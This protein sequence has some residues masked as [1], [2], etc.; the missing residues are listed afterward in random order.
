MGEVLCSI[1]TYI[2]HCD[3]SGLMVLGLFCF[4]IGGL[5]L[6]TSALRYY[7]DCSVVLTR[8]LAR[9]VSQIHSTLVAFCALSSTWL[10]PFRIRAVMP[11][12]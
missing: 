1:G 8:T 4:Y 3:V 12:T 10:K 11:Q 2:F 9:Y 6:P 5:P 7:G